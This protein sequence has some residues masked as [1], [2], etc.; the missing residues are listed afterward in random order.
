MVRSSTVL[1]S[2]LPDL[3][4]VLNP[5]Q[6][7]VKWYWSSECKQAFK[8]CN[9]QLTSEMLLV[10]YNP[11]KK[12]RLACDASCYGLG[13]AL[14]QEFQN[15]VERPISYVSITLNKSERNYVQIKLEAL[16]LIIGV[17]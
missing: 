9:N 15:G 8:E 5:L 3:A 7:N 10:R 12:L 1:S 13:S 6:K 16:S 4:T 2:V 11:S 14:S 17:L